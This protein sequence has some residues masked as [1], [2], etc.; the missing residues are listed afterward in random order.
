[1]DITP[2]GPGHCVLLKITVRV[3]IPIK[4]KS[5]SERLEFRERTKNSEDQ[6]MRHYSYT[7]HH[8]PPPRCKSLSLGRID[9]KALRVSDEALSKCNVVIFC[10]VHSFEPDIKITHHGILSLRI[11]LEVLFLDISEHLNPL[12]PSFPSLFQLPGV[13]LVP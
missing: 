3:I 8:Q 7:S 5:E 4:F 2:H 13:N 10:P 9:R 1:M 6:D 12:N 11:I